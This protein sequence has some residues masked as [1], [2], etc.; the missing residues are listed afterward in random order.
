MSQVAKLLQ[1]MDAKV[2]A[3]RGELAEIAHPADCDDSDCLVC[4]EHEEREC[5]VCNYCGAEVEIVHD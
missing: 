5:G 2:A 4:C 1:E 3:I